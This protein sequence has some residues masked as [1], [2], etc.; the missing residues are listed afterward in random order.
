MNTPATHAEA[1]PDDDVKAR[2]LA[3]IERH[4]S[5]AAGSDF[6]C[7]PINHTELLRE[8]QWPAD[9]SGPPEPTWPETELASGPNGPLDE[10]TAA[11]DE[12]E[13]ERNWQYQVNTRAQQIRLEREARRLVD[14]EARPPVEPPPVR[15]LGTLLAEPDIQASY[16]VDQLAPTGGRVMLSAQFK[17]GKSTL[18]GN[19]M[20]AL[21]DR[22]PFLDQFDV[23]HPPRRI[24]LIDT[25][26]DN[27]TLR[28]WLRDQNIRNH[29]A[30]VDVVALRG[31]VAAFNLIDDRIRAQWAERLRQLECDY[32]I[33]DCLRPVLDA[34]GLDEHR[35]AGR[36]LVAFDALLSEA[37]IDNAL[38][39]QHMG[40]SNERARGDSRLQDWPDAIWRLVRED[41]D[42]GSARFFS[43][44]GRDVDVHEGRL[45]FTPDTR[46]LA[47]AGGSRR[48]AKTEAALPEL[49]TVL[50]EH[51][52]QSG[53]GLS[54]RQIEDAMAGSEHTRNAIRG[55]SISEYEPQATTQTLRSNETDG[56][57]IDSARRDGSNNRW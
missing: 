11:D 48:D 4:R 43:A 34:L 2:G 46:R 28:R 24:A 33:L 12:F 31:R 20:R 41:D 30:V 6:K 40:H 35:D 7:N 44:Y 10:N 29:S 53:E 55:S 50:A 21:A 3:A 17:A 22:E 32:L 52:K 37:G 19:L 8:T 26:L 36:F 39:V 9:D 42:P 57:T 14:D 5:G 18:V 25:E 23:R 16:L 1:G 56:D 45:S 13:R 47:Y 27:N 38:M 51:A 15:S 54:G 49:I